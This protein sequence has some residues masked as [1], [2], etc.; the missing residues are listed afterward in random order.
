MSLTIGNYD[1]EG[2]HLT[3]MFLK[4][5][6]GSKLLFNIKI[7]KNKCIIIIMITNNNNNKMGSFYRH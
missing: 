1:L 4:E 7:G 6:V 3:V 5:L 2:C